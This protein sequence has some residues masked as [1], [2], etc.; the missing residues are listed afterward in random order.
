MRWEEGKK[1]GT[2]SRCLQLALISISVKTKENRT[3]TTDDDDIVML[4]SGWWWSSWRRWRRGSR[5][6]GRTTK[7]SS[8]SSIFSDQ[9][10]FPSHNLDAGDFLRRE[11]FE[12]NGWFQ[13][14]S[15]ESFGPWNRRWRWCK[16]SIM[17]VGGGRKEEEGECREFQVI[18]SGLA[19]RSD[20]VGKVQE[21]RLFSTYLE[22][23]H[24]GCL[25]LFQFTNEINI[26]ILLFRASHVFIIN[27]HPGWTLADD[28]RVTHSPRIVAVSKR[29]GIPECLCF[30]DHF[31]LIKALSSLA[32]H[33]FLLINLIGHRGWWH[34]YRGWEPYLV[35]RRHLISWCC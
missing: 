6:Q 5:S 22:W 9:F 16:K 18:I 28:D 11:S 15:S 33:L 17:R 30:M 10:E 3:A 25:Q 27:R 35:I 24:V 32:S 19:F 20:A 29:M 13:C 14:S 4:C 12:S 34:N 21:T 7:P 31:F 8:H 1:M 23:G 2:E 26:Y